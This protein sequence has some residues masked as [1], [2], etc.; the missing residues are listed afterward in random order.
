[1]G[2]RIAP[3]SQDYEPVGQLV[4]R[5]RTLGGRRRALARMRACLWF[6]VLAPAGVLLIGW[7]D[8]LAALSPPLRIGALAAALL[9][10]TA[11]ALRAPFVARSGARPRAVATGGQREPL[12]R[13]IDPIAVEVILPYGSPVDVAGGRLEIDAEPVAAEAV[14]R[15][16]GKRIGLS[17]NHTCV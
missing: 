4:G 15:R 10:A 11:L 3:L 13:R 14:G 7:M 5:L 17:R 1:M 2:T 9:L 16:H 6:L 12:S 8:L